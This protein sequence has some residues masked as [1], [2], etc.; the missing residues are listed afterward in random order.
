MKAAALLEVVDVRR[1]TPAQWRSAAIWGAALLAAKPLL[2]VLGAI[3]DLR[4]ETPMPIVLLGVIVGMT[5]GLLS[6]GLVLIYRTNK[7]I[8]FAHG[9]IGAFGAAVFGLCAV[10]WH[11]PYWVAFPIALAVGGLTASATEVAVVRRLRNAPKIMSVVATLGAG[12]VL[13][14]VGLLINL[15]SSLGGSYPSPVGLPVFR[16]GPLLVT[17]AYSGMLILSPVLVIA[18]AVFLRTSRYGLAMRAAAANPEAARMAGI[19]SGRMSGLVW[20]LAGVL[21]TFSAILTQPTQGFLIGDAFGPGLLLR[22]LVG[23]VLA[24]MQSLPQAFA[25]GIA[26]GVGEQVLLWNYPS[27][28]LLQVSMFAIILIALLAQRQ[29]LGRDEDKGAWASVQSMKPV[30]AALRSIWLVRNL[31][32]I[33]A[34][35]V[36]TGLM[37]TPLVIDNSNSVRVITILCFAMVGLSVAVLTGLA[38]QLT[39]G[40]FAIASLGAFISYAVATRTGN[41]PLAFVYGGV[42]SGLLAVVLGLPALRLRGMILTVTTLSFALMTPE[43]LIPRLIGEGVQPGRPILPGGH[44]LDTGREYL[45]FTVVVFALVCLLAHNVRSSGLGRLMVAVRDNEDN[46][47]AFTVRSARVKVQGFFVAGFIAGIGGATYGHA[48]SVVGPSSFPS[49]SSIDVVVMSV[50]GGV[51]TLAGPLLGALLVIGIPTFVPLGSVGLVATYAGQLLILLYL[52]GGLASLVEGLRDRLVR[53]IALRKGIDVEAAYAAETADTAALTPRPAT[54]T[55]RRREPVSSAGAGQV[56]LE[57][58]H[59]S[60]SFGGVHAV[61]DVSFSVARGETVGL[62]GPNGAGKTTTFELLGGFTRHDEGRVLFSGRDVSRTSPEGRA[63]LGLI[64]SFQDA[65]LFPTMTVTESVMLGLERTK[66]T[67]FWLSMTGYSRPDRAKQ[68][69]AREL[70]GYMGLDRYRAKQIRELSTGTRRIT[71]LACLI[72]LE[73]TFLLLDEPSS[74]I[75]QRETEALGGVL[76]NLKR[77]LGLTLLVIEHDIPLITSISDRIVA[78]AD[79][80]VIATGTPDQVMA[81]AAVVTAYL[82]GD[83]RTIERSDRREPVA[84]S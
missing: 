30:P 3:L 58:R 6:V 13:L 69:A 18:I 29:R 36:G 81:D 62:I 41:Y 50:I 39:L 66:P 74:G 44:A 47:R 17:E 82:G 61:R 33:T 38:G 2:V 22:A 75:A 42:G 60:K 49:G 4:V 67:S 37:L 46:A 31:G 55:A 70:V 57:A 20:A 26:L 5:Y 45:W 43:W 72:A 83:V 52:P 71:E 34:V 54:L 48:L 8:N 79:G 27:S 9:Q 59:L 32:I 40:Q 15:Q 7:I 63:Q 51:T 14:A 78:M 10:K 25:A 76:A 35:L 24:R 65:A 77:E 68:A 80:E 11:I 73:P 23:A 56:L 1:V 16:V 84:V 21:T 12:Q 53:R 64:R 28:G 19:Y